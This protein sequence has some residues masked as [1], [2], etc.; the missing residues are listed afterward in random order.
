M[1]HAG[2]YRLLTLIKQH[3]S[4]DNNKWIWQFT[5]L[6]IDDEIIQE[7]TEKYKEK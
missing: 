6:F 1:L 7:Y 3:V 4:G 5:Y 2:L